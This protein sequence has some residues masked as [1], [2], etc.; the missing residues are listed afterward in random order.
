MIAT[1]VAAL[2]TW[3]IAYQTKFVGCQ[4]RERRRR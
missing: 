4:K 1:K 2:H 3:Q